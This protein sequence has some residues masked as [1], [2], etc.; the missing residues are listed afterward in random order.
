[1][2]C[3]L[4]NS[5]ALS[6]QL[7]FECYREMPWNIAACP[8]CAT[9]IQDQHSQL[10]GHCLKKPPPFDSATCPLLYRKPINPLML[11][12]KAGDQVCGRFLSQQF[13]DTPAPSNAPIVFVPMHRAA[14]RQRGFNQAQYFAK[15]LSLQWQLRCLDL[16]SCPHAHHTQKGLSAAERRK[17]LCDSF[18]VKPNKKIPESIILVDDVMTTGA[19]MSTLSHLLRRYGVKRIDVVC[20]ARTPPSGMASSVC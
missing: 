3:Y 16:I 4:C 7:C 6:G 8:R 19:T 12:F 17:N 20:L 14:L 15:Q 2:M 1:M 9:P 18:A 5:P 10:C 11:R 13:A